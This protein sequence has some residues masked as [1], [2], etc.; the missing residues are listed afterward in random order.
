LRHSEA[1]KD[2]LLREYE[3]RDEDDKRLLGVQKHLHIGRY[4]AGDVRRMDRDVYKRDRDLAAK[5]DEK[6]KTAVAR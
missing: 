5:L 3:S 1:E 4:E 2:L 6:I